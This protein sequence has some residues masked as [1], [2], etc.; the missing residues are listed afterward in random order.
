[1]S[2]LLWNIKTEN[3]LDLLD[4]LSSDLPYSRSFLQLCLN[5]GLKSSSDIENFIKPDENWIHDPFLLFDMDKTVQRIFQAI[6]EGEKVLIYGDYDADGVTS[7]SILYE[8]LM[9][10]GANVSY[11]IPNRFTDGYGPNLER[12]KEAIDEGCHLIVTV[13]NGVSGH[14]AINYAK[15][16][17]VDVIVTDHHEMPNELPE[18]YAIVHPKHPKGNYP[19]K[20][21]A[22]AG[23]ALKVAHALLEEVPI[24]F[25]DIAAIGTIADMVSLTDENRAIVYFGLMQLKQTQRIGLRKLIVDLDVKLSEVDEQ[26]VGFKIAPV[27]NAIGRL[28][29]AN[30]VV[31]LMTLFDEERAAVISGHLIEVNEQRK[32]IVKT[33][34]EDA[35]K[36]VSNESEI[37]ILKNEHWHEGVLGIV[38]SRIVRETGKP[39]IILKEFPADGL[40]KGSARSVE[41]FDLYQACDSVR[42][43]FVHFGGHQMAAGMTLKTE[44]LDSLEQHLTDEIIRLKETI[45][46]KPVLQIDS[47]LDVDDVNLEMIKELDLLKPFGMDNPTPVFLFKEVKTGLSRKIGK[48]KDHLKLS[49]T[50]STNQLDSIGFSFGYIEEFISESST[51]DIVGKLEKNEWNGNKKPQLMIEDIELKSPKIIDKRTNQL[52]KTMLSIN[53]AIYICFK[54]N[55]K[56]AIFQLIPENSEVILAEEINSNRIDVNHIVIVDCPDD[57]D[58]LFYVYPSIKNNIMT[59]YF[60][61]PNSIYL[62]GLPKIDQCKQVYKYLAQHPTLPLHEL[63]TKLADYLKLSKIT[64]NLILKMF[65]EVNFVKIEDG[66]LIFINNNNKIELFETNSYQHYQEVMN[67]EKKLLYSSKDELIR[68]FSDIN[69]K[70]NNEE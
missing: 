9:T 8:T 65:L 35:L 43:L 45:D 13:D 15:T 25:F 18:A 68:L 5:R 44:N 62:N 61:K 17:E 70:A 3:N 26:T 27:I 7:T 32:D 23:V 42:E 60:Y 47:T 48:D 34:V 51:M 14:E 33:I 41:S 50:S 49:L 53:H 56:E 4:E 29:H 54:Q 31:E 55:T 10:L 36:R 37:N 69:H 67:T 11:Y 30:S 12:Y 46:I 64:F 28:E 19:F 24:E 40:V 21:L 20:E 66:Q 39:T 6:E 1:M 16:R 57:I 59:I 2:E 22:G 58:E 52:S 38:A 63:Q